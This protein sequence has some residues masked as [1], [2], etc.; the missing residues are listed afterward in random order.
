M[1]DD[2]T[3]DELYETFPP[4]SFVNYSSQRRKLPGDSFTLSS[5]NVYSLTKDIL[6]PISILCG[7]PVHAELLKLNFDLE[8]SDVYVKAFRGATSKNKED[9][10]GTLVVCLPN[11]FLGGRLFLKHKDEDQVFDWG[12]RSSKVVQWAFMYPDVKHHTEPVWSGACLTLSFDI[13]ASKPWLDRLSPSSE[14]SLSIETISIGREL[15]ERLADLTFL[16]NGGTLAFALSHPYPVPA[17]TGLFK[18]DFFHQLKGAD[19]LLYYAAVS[20]GLKAEMRSVYEV[21]WYDFK[22]CLRGMD[23]YKKDKDTLTVRQ[24]SKG[25]KSNTIL[26]DE[27]SPFKEF[28][29]P[30]CGRGFMTSTV[31]SVF[32]DADECPDDSA[33]ESSSYTG[34]LITQCRAE[35]EADV[36]WA[37]LPVGK[38]SCSINGACAIE[39]HTM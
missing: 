13:L 7:R 22:K 32:A 18:K 30:D 11:K 19:A 33:E 6:P 4:S 35:I 38:Q 8:K 36:I 21:P 12:E 3:R 9:H 34:N 17:K 31:T 1:T 14:L 5:P 15:K 39:W 25:P 2:T 10:V 27:F 29:E 26:L 16:P 37:R 24:R 23:G 28:S 20:L